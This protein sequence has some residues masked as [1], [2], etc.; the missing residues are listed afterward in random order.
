MNKRMIPEAWTTATA[1]TE[2]TIAL[3]SQNA[4]ILGYYNKY[5]R[6]MSQTPW[7]INGTKLVN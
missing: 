3:K 2:V 7:V 6:F 1:L 4:Y 5:S